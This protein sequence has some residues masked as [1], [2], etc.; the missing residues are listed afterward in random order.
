LLLHHQVFF[1]RWFSATRVDLRP[2]LPRFVA[3]RPLLQLPLVFRREPPSLGVVAGN[4]RRPSSTGPPSPEIIAE[5]RRRRWE[6]SPRAAASVD[7]ICLSIGSI[8]SIVTGSISSLSQ[9]SS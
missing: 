8:L 6:S 5:G 2:S 9:L 7:S 1:D 3:E 4:R